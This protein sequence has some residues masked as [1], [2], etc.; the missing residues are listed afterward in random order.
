M[1]PTPLNGHLN[2][3]Q[4]TA[5]EEHRIGCNISLNKDMKVVVK[6][7]LFYNKGMFQNEFFKSSE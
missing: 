5:G 3:L 1:L 4:N 7:I 2:A 6:L